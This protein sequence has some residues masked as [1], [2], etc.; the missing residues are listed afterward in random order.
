MTNSLL[1]L[2]LNSTAL[3]F[4]MDIDAM[5]HNA[6]LGQS[7]GRAITDRCEP[8]SAPFN[9]GNA[10][11]HPWYVLVLTIV[12]IGGWSWYA[13]M[14]ERGLKDIGNAFECLCHLSGQCL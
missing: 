2:V 3:G 4:L 14:K 5:I 13:Y 6:F 12:G 1:D 11:K 7:F 10:T 9:S 8:L